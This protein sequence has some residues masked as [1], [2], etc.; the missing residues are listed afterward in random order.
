MHI[1][2]YI[3]IYTYSRVKTCAYKHTHTHTTN[4]TDYIVIQDT[5]LGVQG[6]NNIKKK[7]Q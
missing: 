5:L 4:Y 6:C 1:Y 7:K 3:Y 2:L